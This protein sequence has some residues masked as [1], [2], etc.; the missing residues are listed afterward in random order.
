MDLKTKDNKLNNKC[1]SCLNITFSKIKLLQIISILCLWVILIIAIV[2]TQIYFQSRIKT[3]SVVHFAIYLILCLLTLTCVGIIGVK[4]IL[5]TN[6][7]KFDIILFVSILI[8][9][10]LMIITFAY[11]ISGDYD[12]YL[13]GWCEAYRNASFGEALKQ[14]TTVSNYTPFYNYILIII[15]KIGVYDL[16]AIKFVTFIFSILLSF[17]ICKIVALVK[18][19][20]FNYILFA[21]ILLLPF[22]LIEYSLWGQCDAIYTAFCLF[23]L[24]FALKKRSKLSFLFLGL[25]FITKLQFL[26]IVPILFVMLIVKDENN[27]H[28]LKWK[29]IWIAPAMY[30]LNFLPVFAG[31]SIENILLVYVRQ[32]GIDYGLSANCANLCG[33]YPESFTSKQLLSKILIILHIVITISLLIAFLIFVLKT[34]KT[35]TLK[36]EELVLFATVFAFV[37]VFFMPKMLDRFFF[38]PVCLSLINSKLSKDKWNNRI[39]IAMCVAFNLT[40]FGYMFGGIFK[41]VLQYFAIVVNVLTLTFIIIKLNQDYNFKKENLKA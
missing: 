14:I 6:R 39:Y 32:T 28:Y 7:N 36:K 38:I 3:I 27:E 20:Q 21:S 22:I 4:S 33:L 17:V 23:A 10:F 26:F 8:T 5:K 11:V 16:F 15:A 37:M 41:L 40:I 2:F 35:K 24:L 34:A 13:K 18:Q 31:D 29:D 19:N 25:A 1:D 12:V 30:L 9:I